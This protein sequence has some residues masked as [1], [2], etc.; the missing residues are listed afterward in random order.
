MHPDLVSTI[1]RQRMTILVNEAKA[2]RIL[3]RRQAVT[4]QRRSE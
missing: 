1:F 4:R 3:R 2:E